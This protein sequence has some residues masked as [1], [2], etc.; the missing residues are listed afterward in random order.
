MDARI[1]PT[2]VL[3]HLLYREGESVKQILA[4]PLLGLTV[5]FGTVVHCT[6][7]KATPGATQ[8]TSQTS[9]LSVDQ[10]LD[11]HVEAAGGMAAARK[12]TSL[13]ME[14]TFEWPEHG[15]K[16][17]SKLYFSPPNKRVSYYDSYES[18]LFFAS[19]FNGQVSWVN[20]LG[21]G[22]TVERNAG[23]I[24]EI[25]RDA[26]FLR[27]FRL[28]ELYPQR[29]L[30]GREKVDEREAYVVEATQ[31][32]GNRETLYFDVQTGLL[33]RRDETS[34]TSQ[35]EKISAQTYYDDYREVNGIKIPCTITQISAHP[36]HSIIYVHKKVEANRKFANDSD[37]EVP[38]Q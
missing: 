33:M 25:K 18:G 35:G 19:G 31:M 11:R 30:K 2:L 9:T 1:V 16:G 23:R 20:V 36:D 37:F 21:T 38:T 28:K 5:T 17:N 27:D 4:V 6:Q 15:V 22:I 26:T 7:R 29:K 10:V 32:D 13:G 14:G 12:I 34:T 3:A 24:A 8:G